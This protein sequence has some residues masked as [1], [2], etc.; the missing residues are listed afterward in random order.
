MSEDR[1]SNSWMTNLRNKENEGKDFF[2]HRNLEQL[3][4]HGT[5][6]IGL[7]KSEFNYLV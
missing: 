1:N 2:V 4:D 5:F 3:N 7:E 6:G